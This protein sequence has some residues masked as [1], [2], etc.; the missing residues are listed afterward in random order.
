MTSFLI[1]LQAGEDLEE[2]EDDKLEDE[3]QPTVTIAAPESSETAPLLGSSMSS[4]HPRSRSR[5]RQRA[6]PH[7]NAT[8]TQAVLMV[9]RHGFCC[10]SDALTELT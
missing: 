8:V 4:T 3:E 6:A 10:S 5:S 1:T 9:K 7:G 2:D